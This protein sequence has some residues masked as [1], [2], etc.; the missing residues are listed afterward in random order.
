MN[1][2]KLIRL[3]VIILVIFLAL[4]IVFLALKIISEFFFWIVLIIIGVFAYY[5]LPRM[6][7]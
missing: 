4:N 5:Y 1:D 7:K 2:R 3:L 6:K